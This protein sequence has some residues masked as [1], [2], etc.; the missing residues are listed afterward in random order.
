LTPDFRRLTFS[1]R[2]SQSGRS[3]PGSS[4]VPPLTPRVNISVDAQGFCCDFTGHV[5]ALPREQ[6]GSTPLS[7]HD[8][9]FPIS[10]T[11]DAA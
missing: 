6:T 7:G 9:E 8:K 1:A 11:G 4:A 5:I 2:L 10:R 3:V